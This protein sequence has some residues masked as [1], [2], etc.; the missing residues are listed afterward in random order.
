MIGKHSTEALVVYSQRWRGGDTL[1]ASKVRLRSLRLIIEVA[2]V[3][4]GDLIPN[5]GLVSAIAL[6]DDLPSDTHCF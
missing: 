4:D 3:L 2:C 6:C 5:V 1:L